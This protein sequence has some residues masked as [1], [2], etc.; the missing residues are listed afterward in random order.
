MGAETCK[1]GCQEDGYFIRVSVG[2]EVC[3]SANVV[4][5]TGSCSPL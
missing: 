4:R 2:A 1:Y 5:F 3:E